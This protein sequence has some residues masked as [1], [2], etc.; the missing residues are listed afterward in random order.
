MLDN[1]ITTLYHYSTLH[2]GYHYSVH[3]QDVK[4]KVIIIKIHRPYAGSSFH[5]FINHLVTS[6]SSSTNVQTICFPDLVPFSVQNKVLDSFKM[7][8]TDGTDGILQ[9][10]CCR[11]G[12]EEGFKATNRH[13]DTV[14][15]QGFWSNGKVC[16]RNFLF[17]TCRGSF[18]FNERVYSWE[19]QSED[20]TG[21][22][23]TLK[24]Y[25]QS[26]F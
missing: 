24:I 1:I 20:V 3:I 2:T 15:I 22:K 14:Q 9:R 5:H 17:R 26:D 18:Y 25:S 21:T 6:S 23:Y 8:K 10:F 12:F 11:S 19:E 13:I 7:A 4:C 16:V